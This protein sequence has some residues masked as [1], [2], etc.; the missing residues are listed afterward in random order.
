[1]VLKAGGSMTIVGSP[2][3]CA[4]SPEKPGA[5]LVKSGTLDGQTQH[6]LELGLS[7]IGLC[8]VA[9]FARGR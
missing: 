6:Q 4:Q 7:R 8:K 1:M 5:P 2:A 9:S 3:E